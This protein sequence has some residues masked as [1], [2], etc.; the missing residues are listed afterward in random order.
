[1]YLRYCTY[2]F[3]EEYKLHLNN[4]DRLVSGTDNGTLVKASLSRSNMDLK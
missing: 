3:V 1:M 4:S 2:L